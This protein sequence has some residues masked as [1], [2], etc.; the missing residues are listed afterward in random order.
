MENSHKTILHLCADIGSDS[1]PY[2]DAGYNV[3]CVG[4]D[5][6][7]EN[8]HPPENIYGVIANPP[9]TM[10]SI[11]RTKAKTP[12]DLRQGMKAVKECLRIIWECIYLQYDE[13]TRK[14]PLKFWAIENPA[15]GYLRWFLGKPNFEYCQ[16]WYDAPFTKKTALWGQ[17]NL[18]QIPFMDGPMQDGVRS[19]GGNYGKNKHLCFTRDGGGKAVCPEKFAKAFFEVNQ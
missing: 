4:K 11:A 3:I 1:K 6:G 18:P 5:I 7:V 14:M 16:S 15:T 13:S 12:R 10:F 2:K 9:C 17:F 19:R 8:Y